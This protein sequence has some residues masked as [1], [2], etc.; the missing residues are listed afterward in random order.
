MNAPEN[1]T[2][3]LAP[4]FL[5][6]LGRHG[7][8]RIVDHEIPDGIKTMM[9]EGGIPRTPSLYVSPE[10]RHYGVRR[11]VTLDDAFIGFLE[12]YD[13]PGA[14][15]YRGLVPGFATEDGDPHINLVYVEPDPRAVRPGRGDGWK[16]PFP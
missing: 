5:A 4:N 13:D 6:F 16:I 10:G 3:L 12:T 11:A 2:E 8:A 1:L 14:L 15:V 7:R 9:A